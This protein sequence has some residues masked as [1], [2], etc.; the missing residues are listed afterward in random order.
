MNTFD[1][2]CGRFGTDDV[3]NPIIYSR[4]GGVYFNLVIQILFLSS[5]ITIY[6]YGS[7][8]KFHRGF[9]SLKDSLG[10]AS[11][12]GRAT[13]NR[14]DEIP[15][16][17]FDAKRQ[18]HRVRSMVG[19]QQDPILQILRVTKHFGKSTASQD[20]SFDVH[21]NETMALLGGN[22]AGKTTLFNMIRGELRPDQ[23]EIYVNS[24]SVLK[25]PRKSRIHIGAC[26]QDDAVDSLTV[27]QTLE[28]YGSIKGLKN[29]RDNAKQVLGA[30]NIRRF[31]HHAHKALSGGTKRKLTVAIALLGNPRLLLLDEPSTGQDAGAKRLLWRALKRVSKDRAILLTTHSME[32]AEALASKATIVSTRMLATGTLSSLQEQYG[33]FYKIRAVRTDRGVQTTAETQVRV[34]L[35]RW[36]IG[37]ENYWDS[38]GLVQ[39]NIA[40]HKDKLGRI[41]VGMEHLTGN[42]DIISDPATR[43]PLQ[44]HRA[45]FSTYDITGHTMED[46]IMNVVRSLRGKEQ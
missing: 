12:T 42:N 17:N 22:G 15:L 13:K 8:E 28:F 14:D 20:I 3:S 44:E 46:V 4:Y 32:E 40:Y 10:F 21:E 1:T 2:L 5:F 18:A 7:A 34:V 43:S 16:T 24:I 27:R 33:G 9:S 36:G 19:S 45:I 23:G 35:R 39:F 11:S 30:L 38:N 31:E 37:V 25:Q 41:M 26:P 29:V 6:E